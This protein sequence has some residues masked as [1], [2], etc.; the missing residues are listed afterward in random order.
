M[1]TGMAI[2]MAAGDIRIMV[3]QEDITAT[4]AAWLADRHIHRE[5]QEVLEMET[6]R[7]IPML[8]VAERAVDLPQPAEV[9]LLIK[10]LRQEVVIAD[11]P[12]VL[13]N[14]KPLPIVRP[15]QKDLLTE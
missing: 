7:K 10:P 6:I 8:V 2:T 14:K 15:G 1:A 3:V 11:I 9:L 4:E 12:E 5:V 13:L